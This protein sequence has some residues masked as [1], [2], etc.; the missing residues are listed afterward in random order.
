MILLLRVAYNF[1]G[2]HMVTTMVPS[3]LIK[4]QPTDSVI[5]YNGEDGIRISG[6]DELVK[7]TFERIVS[8][9]HNNKRHFCR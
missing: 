7:V 5:S 9:H 6:D 8:S 4:L 3:S 1:A 2:M